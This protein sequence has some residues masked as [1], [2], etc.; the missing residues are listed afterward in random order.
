[1]N[2]KHLSKTVEHYTPLEVLAAVRQVLGVI[3][4]DPASSWEAQR[5][6]GALNYITQEGDGLAMSWASEFG[7]RSVFLNP[8]G[9]KV[10][11]QSVS[12]LWWEKLVR[13]VYLGHVSHAIFLAFNLEMLQT[14]QSCVKPMLD[15]GLCYPRERLRFLDSQGVPQTSPTHANVIAYIPGTINREV[16]FYRAF[17]HIGRVNLAAVLSPAQ[18][19]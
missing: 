19:S 6:V 2:P 3:E 17:S 14:T 5:N 1:M 7:P 4:L 12:K 15:Y 11:N 18:L 10:V 8:P 13:E 9:G 16:E